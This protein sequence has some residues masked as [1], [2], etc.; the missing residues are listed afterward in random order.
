MIFVTPTVYDPTSTLNRE[1]LDK[2]QDMQDKFQ[3][4]LGPKGIV[5]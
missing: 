3:R 2:A 1:R 5:D 4:Q